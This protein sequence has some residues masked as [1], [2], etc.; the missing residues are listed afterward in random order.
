MHVYAET[1]L[2]VSLIISQLVTAAQIAAVF[3]YTT[4]KKD[5]AIKTYR[6]AKSF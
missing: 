6:Y 1:L 2:Y 3:F 4:E 5:F